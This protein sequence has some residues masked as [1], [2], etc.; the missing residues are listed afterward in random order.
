MMFSMTID[1]LRDRDRPAGAA[2]GYGSDAGQAAPSSPA[3]T[4]RGS[5]QRSRAKATEA[6]RLRRIGL[7]AIADATLAGQNGFQV[8]SLVNFR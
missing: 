6:L 5:G 2:T 3:L 1:Q 7:V 8:G 4:L